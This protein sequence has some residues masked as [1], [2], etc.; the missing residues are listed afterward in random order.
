MR[1]YVVKESVSGHC[2]F[3]ASV[4]DRIAVEQDEHAEPVCECYYVADAKRICKVMELMG[5]PR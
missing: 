4:M 2:C 3:T 5:M 1:Y